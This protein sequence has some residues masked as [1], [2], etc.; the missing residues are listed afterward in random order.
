MCTTTIA[1]SFTYKPVK[2]HFKLDLL[3]AYPELY[4]DIYDSGLTSS[5]NIL[6]IKVPKVVNYILKQTT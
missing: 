3:Q 5:I 6:G 1:T 4:M 2:L